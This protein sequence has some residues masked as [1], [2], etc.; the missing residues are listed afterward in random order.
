MVSNKGIK[1]LKSSVRSLFECWQSYKETTTALSLYGDKC[2]FSESLSFHDACKL[3]AFSAEMH[4]V[5][6]GLQFVC[7]K[8]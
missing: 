7:I 3:W 2:V 1:T 4:H 5:V 8:M 6:L